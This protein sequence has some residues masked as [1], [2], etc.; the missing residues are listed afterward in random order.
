MKQK[1]DINESTDEDVKLFLREIDDTVGELIDDT[2][3]EYKM[4]DK[5]VIK[6]LKDLETDLL[7]FDNPDSLGF[8]LY[9]SY[10]KRKKTEIDM[11][12]PSISNKY[13]KKTKRAFELALN[14]V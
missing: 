3:S 4:G 7:D 5:R 14:Y 1:S 12:D 11:N 8:I 9:K 13:I 10:C 6:A 2:V